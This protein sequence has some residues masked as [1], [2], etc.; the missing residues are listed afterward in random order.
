MIKFRFQLSTVNGMNGLSELAQ[1]NAVSEPE[2]IPESNLLK[3][4]TEEPVPA[5]PRKLKS[6]WT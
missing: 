6:V 2:P 3:N 1:Q 5:N 4:L